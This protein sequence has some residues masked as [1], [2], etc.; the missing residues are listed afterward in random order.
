MKISSDIPSYYLSITVFCIP[1]C[2][3]IIIIDLHI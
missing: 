2:Q 1:T 3:K